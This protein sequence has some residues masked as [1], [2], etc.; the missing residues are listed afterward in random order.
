ME[1]TFRFKTGALN[2]VHKLQTDSANI[3][4]EFK[5]YCVHMKDILKF[6][7]TK[8]FISIASYLS[9]NISFKPFRTNFDHRIIENLL[10]GLKTSAPLL[11][12]DQLFKQRFCAPTLLHSTRASPH[13]YDHRDRHL[14]HGKSQ[15]FV[16]LQDLQ[17][18][19]CLTICG[20]LAEGR[21]TDVA[22]FGERRAAGQVK[23]PLIDEPA[24]QIPFYS[25]NEHSQVRQ[26]NTY[27]ST[28][29]FA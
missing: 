26:L 12:R 9:Y 4:I 15:P 20:K 27:H 28:G 3:K 1:K 11:S 21:M 29:F 18:K 16:Q 8:Q 5:K 14:S 10:T 13:Y 19:L 17:P 2:N 25:V 24:E 23:A 6:S 7:R 22:E